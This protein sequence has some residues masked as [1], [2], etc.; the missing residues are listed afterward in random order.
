MADGLTD[1]QREAR[2]FHAENLVISTNVVLRNDGLPRSD[3]RAPLDPGVAVYFSLKGNRMVLACDKWD[4]VEDN[5]YAI[6]CHV[7][8][9]RRQ[10][11]LGVGS[12]EQAFAGYTALPAPGTFKGATWWNVLGCAHDAPIEVVKSAYLEKAKAA[13][14]DSA[15]GSH[16]KMIELNAAWDQARAAFEPRKP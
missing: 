16:D 15:G 4:R 10:Q 13:H 14:P 6:A 5:L 2:A 12:V 9:I 7:E 8:A 11:R 3:Q 1:M